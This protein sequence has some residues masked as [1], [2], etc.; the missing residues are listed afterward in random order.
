MKYTKNIYTMGNYSSAFNISNNEYLKQDR[1]I[2]GENKIYIGVV[3]HKLY[4]NPYSS[5]AI[6]IGDFGKLYRLEKFI[7]TPNSLIFEYE[8]NTSMTLSK[9]EKDIIVNIKE[10]DT[11]TLIIKPMDSIV[12]EIFKPIQWSNLANEYDKIPE[13]I[14]PKFADI[15]TDLG[16]KIASGGVV[17]Q[18]PIER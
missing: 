2:D 14:R 17:S 12:R 18:Q 10:P 8:S 6:R 16:R 5:Q 13:F 11:N 1:L 7:E 9:R 3:S 4:S 15:K